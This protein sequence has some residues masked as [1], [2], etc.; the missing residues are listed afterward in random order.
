MPDVRPIAPQLPTELDT[1]CLVIDLDIVERNAGRMAD[2]VGERGIALRPHIKTHKSVA[3]ARMQIAAGAAGITVGTLGEAEVMAEG[4]I[5][6]IALCY[7]LWADGRKA[8]RLRALHEREALNFAVGVDSIAG[9]ERLAAAVAGSAR[10]LRV[11]I[12]LDPQYH[13]TGVDPASTGELATKLRDMGLEVIGVFTHGGHAYAGRDGIADAAADEVGAIAR[14]A[15][16]LRAA[17][18]EPQVLSAGSTPTA[19]SAA[20]GEVNEVRPGTYLIN[21]RIQVHMGSCPVDGVA[22]AVAATVVSDSVPGKFVINAG[23]KS[24]TKDMPPYLIGY[25]FI[26]DYPTGVLER[27]SDYHGEVRL[28]DGDDGPRLGDVVAVIPN[29]VC[30]VIDL[31]DT[32]VATR[33]GEIVGRWPVD[34][35]GRS[36]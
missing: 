24:L 7:P 35:R 30:P 11:L 16:S 32:F 34:A 15:E 22:V 25:G 3:L 28:P 18:F 4:G 1:P 20:T 23:A 13:R 8:D 9:A 29:H 5:N 2:A 10:A 26:P 14:A 21:D 33:G 27:L 19:L 6:D 36:G 17:G 12:E 31:F